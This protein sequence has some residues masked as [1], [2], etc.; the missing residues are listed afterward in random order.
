MPSRWRSR[1]QIVLLVL[2]AALV[3]SAV[4]WLP[5]LVTT[6]GAPP[7]GVRVASDVAY[8]LLAVLL[9]FAVGFPVVASMQSQ[10]AGGRRRGARPHVAHMR[11]EYRSPMVLNMAYPLRVGLLQRLPAGDSEE[12]EGLGDVR[13]HVGDIAFEAAEPEPVLT[14]TPSSVYCR[15]APPVREI[16]L[17]HGQDVA[18]EFEV[19]PDKVP[20]GAGGACTL[21]VD[22]DYRGLSLKRIELPVQIR[23]ALRVGRWQLPNKV[24][25][26]FVGVGAALN[27][28]ATLFQVY[29]FTAQVFR[30]PPYLVWFLLSLVAGSGVLALGA[31]LWSRA[32]RRRALTLG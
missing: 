8:G 12:E 1:A 31:H 26:A 5:A 24:W 29:D 14:V 13:V 25:P 4:L 2:A 11:I 30:A 7:T 27:V 19:L 6:L 20:S 15:I 22:L 9:L 18:A 16:R 17:I 3:L 23:Q 10:G 21:S 32:P 28:A